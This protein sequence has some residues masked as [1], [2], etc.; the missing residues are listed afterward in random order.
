[1]T[2]WWRRERD[3]DEEIAG[4]LRMAAEDHAAG[5]KSAWEAKAAARSEFGNVS[6]IK[7]V[8]R[9][10]W[11][12]TWLDR[13]GQDVR[14]ALRLFRRNPGLTISAVLTLAIGIGANTAIFAAARAILLRPLPYTDPDRL[15]MVWQGDKNGPPPVR[16]YATPI[17]ALE[18]RARNASFGDLAVFEPWAANPILQSPEGAERLLAT[19]ASPNFFDLLGVAAAIGR[20]FS[21]QDER[22]G[23]RDLIVL[24]HRLWRT[25]FGGDPAVLGRVIDLPFGRD[26]AIGRLTVIGV[27]PE[28]FRFTYPD[29]TQVWLLRPWS[30]IER[31][32]GLSLQYQTIARLKPDVSL[33]QARANLVAVADSMVRDLPERYDARM[34]KTFQ[35]A[36]AEDT[37]YL[38]PIQEYVVGKTRPALIL[39]GVATAFLLV[40]ACSN[41]AALLLARTVQRSRE[42]SLRV[43]LGAAPGRVRRQLFTEGLV[44][45]VAGGAAGLLAVALLQPLLRLTLPAS[46]PRVDEMS[47]DLTTA[48]WAVAL[49]LAAAIAAGIAPSWRRAHTDPHAS[50]KQGGG[51]ATGGPLATLWR[52]GLIA[53]QV[54]LVVLLMLGGGLLARTL[55]NLQR[56]DLG[57]ESSNVLTMEML[58]LDV[59]YRNVQALRLFEQNLLSA[60]RALPGVERA[61]ISS[62]IPLR[63]RDTLVAVP[64]ASGRHRVNLRPIDADFF[65]VLRIPL[66]A[67]RLFDQGETGEVVILSESAAALLL[68]SVDP[69]GETVE[70]PLSYTRVRARVV[71]IVADVR[72]LRVEEPGRPAIYVPRAQS[73]GST[74]CLVVRGSGNASGLAGAVREVIRAIDPGQPVEGVTTIGQI[75]AASIADRRFYAVAT[76]GFSLVGLFLAVAG[77]YGV[78]SQSVAERV[79]ELGVRITLGASRR[80]V[81]RLVLR[82]GL[83]PV[84]A[85]LGVGGVAA[86]WTTGLLRRFLFDVAATDPAIYAAVPVLVVVVAAVACW[87]PARRASDV[88]PIEALR[89]E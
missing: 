23:S 3:L 13:A 38:E 27:L 66:R 68:P 67:G 21:V 59:K 35:S 63:G 22:D 40:V 84:V 12:W 42:L 81:V 49:A 87:I 83:L 69:L 39:L 57:F 52:R 64:T 51:P 75:V 65:D 58:M 79:R 31:T 55:W 76:V 48:L 60:V 53:T 1:M 44:L 80:H 10:M 19:W 88:N 62:A 16:G 4:H 82:Q 29:E 28:R 18:W 26:R 36:A 72:Y 37:V 45:A 24:S 11:G 43:A 8:T 74:I 61:S 70:I 78:V 9:D 20:T 73:L 54:A 33:E 2:S 71:G 15:V 89:A 85:G 32:T 5:G 25:R 34:R 17:H 56:V 41:V 30:E 86:F 47:V 6:V 14:Y 7:D 50:L 46:Y 77:L